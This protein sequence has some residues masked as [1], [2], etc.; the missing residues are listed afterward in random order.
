MS[1]KVSKPA[2][3]S[4]RFKVL[5]PLMFLLT[6]VFCIMYFA[7]QSFLRTVISRFMK[8]ES[9]Y[10]RN[11]VVACIDPDMLGGLTQDAQ[12]D[13]ATDWRKDDRFVKVHDCLVDGNINRER[14]SI[15][16]YYQTGENTFAYGV[17]D[18]AEIADAAPFGEEITM[19][20]L[21]GIWGKDYGLLA[22]GLS[23]E[24]FSDELYY[25]EATD[26][27]LFDI[28]S[29][30]QDGA[31]NTV[32]GVF[33]VV[34]ANDFIYDLDSLTLML[35]GIFVFIYIFIALV[36]LGVIGGATSQLRALNKAA[37]R[38]AEGDYTPV[39]VRKQWVG[40]EVFNLAGV[41]NTMLEKVRGR[42]ETLKKRVTELE[43]VIDASKKNK[44]VQEIVDSEFFQGLTERATRI[45][46]SRKRDDQG[47]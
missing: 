4:I 31:G 28:A 44:Q 47:K 15:F 3:L 12:A 20:K 5:I 22:G 38:V 29:P 16:T 21:G 27:N 9:M 10:I 41:F 6:I 45:R 1:T 8:Q 19:E 2:F 25:D 39:K 14:A 7:S 46:A 32:G 36:V 18:D 26:V 30:I 11:A 35:L 42:E 40:D 34:K 37:V 13:P 23:G 17:R 24:S 33:V 43:I